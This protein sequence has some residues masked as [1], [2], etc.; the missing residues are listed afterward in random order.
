MK[1]NFTAKRVARLLKKPGRYR[2][3]EVRGLLLVV[4][5]ADAAS[6]ILRYE[7]DGR[8]RWLGLGPTA[9]VTLKDARDKAR[10][11]RL[12]LLDGHDP[13]EQKR[14]ARAAAKI[15]AAKTLTFEAAAQAYFDEHEK[16]WRNAKNRAQF[17]S[18]LNAYAFP[19][20]GTLP[21]STIDK[22]LVLKVLEQKYQG[23][24]L[25]DV[26]PTTAARVRNRIE[27]ILDCCTVRDYRSGDNPA[28]WRGHLD[29]VL[30]SPKKLQQTKHLAALPYAELP[31]F[32]ATL[33]G[34]PGVTARALEF[35][36]LTAARTGEVIGARWSE[37]DL[38]TR[39]WII[40]AGRMK[41]GKEHRV[42]LSPR[43][44]AI[45]QDLPREQNNAHVFLGAQ[46]GAALNPRT[47]LRLMEQCGLDTT[48][49]GFRSTFR[50]WAG[51]RTA[52]AV[53]VIEISLAHA[54]GSGVERA[55]ARSDLLA[56]RRK[57]MDAWSKYCSSP[58][59]GGDVVPL[60]PV[61]P[62]TP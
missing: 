42:P 16:Q 57:L 3:T 27:R 58:A 38:A 34:M 56:Q 36:I 49:H 31:N 46:P 14:A 47:L 9:L 60:R 39:T 4:K 26:I 55:Y 59:V 61:M 40:P 35:L 2:D 62:A 22:A 50:D 24:R 8:E 48:V 20:I 18:S 28:R 29:N 15:A 54:V 10:D 37:I 6:W 13:L 17:L 41:A 12:Q 23:Q 53:H 51:E 21:V 43:A 25:W 5:H 1:T 7:R 45:L 52:I 19:L 32:M 33:R 11:A 30:A 44:V